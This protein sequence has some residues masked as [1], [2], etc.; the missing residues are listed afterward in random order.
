MRVKSGEFLVFIFTFTFATSASE[1]K[2]P[3]RHFGQEENST[4]TLAC[5]IGLTQ[6][7]SGDCVWRVKSPRICLTKR[8]QMNFSCF[9]KFLKLI[10][11]TCLSGRG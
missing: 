7:V 8:K 6:L 4:Q 9:N 2:Q 1:W 5:G 11:V 10:G 3:I